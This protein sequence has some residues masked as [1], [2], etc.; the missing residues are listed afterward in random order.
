MTA[1][2]VTLRILSAQSGNA[3]CNALMDRF[4]LEVFETTK[5]PGVAFINTV[6]GALIITSS[7]AIAVALIVAVIFIPDVS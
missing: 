1:F 5:Q 7:L 6:W 4:E 3:M 2:L